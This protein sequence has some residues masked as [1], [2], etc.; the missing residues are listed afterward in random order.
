MS[1]PYLQGTRNI[2]EEKEELENGGKYYKCSFG[3]DMA[4]VFINS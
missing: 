4:I 1:F 3:Y 2:V